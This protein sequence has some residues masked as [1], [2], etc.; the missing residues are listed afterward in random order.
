MPHITRIDWRDCF[1]NPVDDLPPPYDAHAPVAPVPSG[2]SATA[3][4][5]TL[6]PGVK[7]CNLITLIEKDSAIRGAY[8]IDPR[9]QVPANLLPPL[10]T[11]QTEAERKNLYLHTRDGTVDISIWLIGP[12]AKAVATPPKKRTTMSVSSND[13]SVTVR[14]NSVDVV[15]PF[16]LDVFAR[17]GRVTVL[18]PQSF[19]GPLFLKARH[20]KNELSEGLLRN[21]TCLG[22]AEGTTR[23][24]VGDF[25]AA[26]GPRWEGDELKVETR[27]G[28]IRVRYVDEIEASSSKG[29]FFS[30]VFSM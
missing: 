22:T 21:S 5:S 13:G 25:Q 19:R 9:L 14:V 6:P 12:N 16:L 17:D 28:K 29:G 7:P 18:L 15:D 30:R 2:S 11:G 8:V 10:I 20:G 23:Y 24:F 27:D 3:P 4:S 1:Q 26:T